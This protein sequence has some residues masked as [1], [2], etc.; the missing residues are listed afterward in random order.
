MKR[1][2]LFA[3]A[4]AVSATIGST[5]FA[6]EVKIGALTI[7]HAWARPS[8]GKRGNSAAYMTIINKGG[9]QDRLIAVTNP[10]VGKA[11]L[12]THIRDGEI[13]WMR[14]VK[15][16]IPVPA[17]GAVELKPGGYHVM[18]MRLKTPVEK[19]GMLPLTLTFEKA[20]TVTVHAEVTMKPAMKGHGAMKMQHK[21]K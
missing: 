5:A 8:I 11:T 4:L 21:P 1:L 7:D 13:M 10:Q 6:A 18:L 20:G 19:G 9:T 2:T 17:H 15:D 3:A 16:G 12:H 14:H